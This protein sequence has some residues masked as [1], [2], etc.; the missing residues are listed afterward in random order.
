MIKAAHLEVSF[1]E[2][3]RRSQNELITL[4]GNINHIP[5]LTR[6]PID[7]D[8]VM[9]ELLETGWVENVVSCWDGVVDVEFVEG[10]AG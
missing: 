7:L 6:F 3:D 10:L 2:R 4:L 9:E 5:Q 1:R 8:P